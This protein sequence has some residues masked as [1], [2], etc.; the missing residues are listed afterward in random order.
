MMKKNIITVVLIIWI[1]FIFF[2]SLQNGTDSAQTSGTITNW[3]YQFL[4][5]LNITVDVNILSL[6]VRK[7]AHVT[8]F[9]ILGILMS[10]YL[11][12]YL[13]SIL[14][15]GLYTIGLCILVAVVDEGIQLLVPKRYGSIADVGIDAIGIIFGWT[16]VYLIVRNKK[17]AVH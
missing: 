12:R 15:H 11:F 1:C 3:I 6:W 16:I 2:N 8:E 5:W 17:K 9:M 4:N 14:Y 13:L 7:A 10:L